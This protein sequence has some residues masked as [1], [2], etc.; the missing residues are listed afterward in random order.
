MSYGEIT[1]KEAIKKANEL[2][3]ELGSNWEPR[4]WENG[5]WH[6]NAVLKLGD[7][8]FSVR[9]YRNGK[10]SCSGGVNR[11]SGTPCHLSD[12]LEYDTPQGAFEGL[13]S[14]Y[15]EYAKQMTEFVKGLT[16]KHY[17]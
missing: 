12:P 8:G 9:K 15:E 7:G 1:K 4:V 6:A 17:E 5:G 16:E 10:Y 13:L 2:V 3:K 11:T 14:N